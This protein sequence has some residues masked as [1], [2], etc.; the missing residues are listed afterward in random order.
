MELLFNQLK[1]FLFKISIYE[2]NVEILSQNCG[3]TS[4][5]K[6]TFESQ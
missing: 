1:L 2:V 6:R 3:F 4:K 5:K